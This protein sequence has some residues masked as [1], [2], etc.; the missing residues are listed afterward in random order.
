[1]LYLGK[2]FNRFELE[3]DTISEIFHA[4]TKRFRNTIIG[5]KLEKGGWGGFVNPYGDCEPG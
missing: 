1:M 4:Q 3:I 5:F 2:Q